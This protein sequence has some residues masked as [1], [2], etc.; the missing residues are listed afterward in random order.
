MNPYRFQVSMRQ[1][2]ELR[3]ERRHRDDKTYIEVM[4]LKRHP[5]CSFV[6]EAFGQSTYRTKNRNLVKVW[7]KGCS[8]SNW[9]RLNR[10]TGMMITQEWS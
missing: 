1:N 9:Y 4:S 6:A 10:F 7:H 5:T 3:I 2:A 8:S